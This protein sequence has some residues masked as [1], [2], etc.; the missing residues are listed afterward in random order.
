M[1]TFWQWADTYEDAYHSSADLT[2]I[3][4]RTVVITRSGL[5]SLETCRRGLATLRSG[6]TAAIRA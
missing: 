3:A 2:Q 1:A 5:S 4:C 6:A